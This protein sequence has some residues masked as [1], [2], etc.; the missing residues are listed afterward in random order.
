VTVA[1]ALRHATPDDAAAIRGICLRTGDAGRDATH[2]H[3][4][5]DLLGLVW[6][7]PYLE[8]EAAHALVA[9]DER[10]R[11]LGYVLAT[12]DSRAFEESAE[13]SYWPPLRTRYPLGP[14]GGRTA[15]DEAAVVLVHRPPL[16]PGPLL[17][18]HPGHL[19]VDLLPEAQGR[20]AGRAL[21]SAAL[22]SLRA[23]GCIG[24]HVGVDP[25]NLPALGFYRRLGFLDL[26]SAP[27]VVHLGVRLESGPE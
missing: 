25:G 14:V 1:L 5:P 20:G 13:A 10:D 23:A 4:D 3:A 6:A 22:D 18:T 17:R 19:H 8:L 2:L 24:A 21:V 15:A 16:A 26:S 7:Q 9:V 11:L 27:D 12:P